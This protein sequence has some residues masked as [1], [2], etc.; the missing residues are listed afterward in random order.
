M[1]TLKLK[2]IEDDHLWEKYDT[3]WYK[4]SA[5]IKKKIDSKSVYNKTFL[6]TKIKSYSDEVTDIHDNEMPGSN[7]TCLAV[8]MIDSAFKNDENYYPQVFFKKMQMH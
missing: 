8:I 4:V 7:L 3:I 2:L 5:D 6:K 1:V